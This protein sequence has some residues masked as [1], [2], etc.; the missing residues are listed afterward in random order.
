MGILKITLL[1]N[2]QLLLMLVKVMTER[3]M[4]YHH[5]L[6]VFMLIRKKFNCFR[7]VTDFLLQK[8]SSLLLNQQFK[9]KCANFILINTIGLPLNVKFIFTVIISIVILLL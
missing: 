6:R 1:N 7:R 9:R 5:D 3:L 4:K 8:Y 2:K